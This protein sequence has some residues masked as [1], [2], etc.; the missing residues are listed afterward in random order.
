MRSF[1]AVL[2]LLIC[3]CPF[4]V[5]DAQE[6]EKPAMIQ[7][8]SEYRFKDGLYL[9]IDDVRNND[10]IPLG[11]V[12]TDLNNYNKDFFD[13]MIIREEI[14]LYDENGVRAS[15]PTKNIWGYA[16][17]GRLYIMLGGKFQRII[18]EGSIS[19]FIASATTYMKTFRPDDTSRYYTTTEDLYR[20]INRKYFYDNVST[21]GN[22]SLFDFE[23]NVLT[24]YNEDNLGKLLERDSILSSEYESLR[25]RE[26]KKNMAAFIRRYN[27]RHPLYFP[28][29]NE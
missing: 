18:I 13:E 19:H 17:N 3:Q 5:L 6:P 20:S 22:M 28:G 27:D 25:K 29:N 12:V 8:S 26:K 16:Q 23:S 14:I 10:P 2:G 9:N 11:R 24:G 21:E 1:L 4:Q 7:F 15:V